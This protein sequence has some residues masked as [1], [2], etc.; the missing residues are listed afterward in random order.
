MRSSILLESTL[1]TPEEVADLPLRMDG[2]QVVRLSDVAEV[3]LD[4]ASF[5]T[6][7]S[8]DGEEGLFVGIYPA[9]GANPLTTSQAV[10]DALPEIEASLP[11]GMSVEVSYDATDAIAASIQEVFI[12]ILQAVVVVV[13]VILLFLGAPRSVIMPVITIPLSLV[14]ICFFMWMA[15]FSINLLTLLAMVLAI[16]LVVDDAIVVVEN[17]QRN[18]DEGMKPMGAA[19]L[20]M[21]ESWVALIA[22]SLALVAVLAP[23]AFTGGLVGQLFTEF[24]LTLAGAPKFDTSERDLSGFCWPTFEFSMG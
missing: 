17:V 5:D 10:N 20:G 8:V 3:E 19:I 21:R 15:G 24:A 6:I 13:L 23:I 2:D 12:T 7:V 18:I 16:G 1:Q 22:T 4:A 11:E 14:G 9:P